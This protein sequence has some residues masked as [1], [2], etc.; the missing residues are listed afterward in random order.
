MH[1]YKVYDIILLTKRKVFYIKYLS[2]DLFIKNNDEEFH[3]N[4][5]D[6]KLKNNKYIF[7]IEKDLYEIEVDKTIRLHKENDESIIDFI[8][9][10]TIEREGTYYIKEL[11]FYM[12]ALVNTTKYYVSKD[13]IT[14]NYSL[15]LQGEEIGDFVLNI[16]VKE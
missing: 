10:D 14:V 3:Y 11:N 1:F 7:K 5:A 13:E 6:C 4:N 15:K 16:K 8:F 12:D 9:D 2:I